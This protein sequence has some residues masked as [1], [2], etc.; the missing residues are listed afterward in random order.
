MLRYNFIDTDWVIHKKKLIDEVGGWDPAYYFDDYELWLR[1]SEN[2]DLCYLN[3]GLVENTAMRFP[4][5]EEPYE[6]VTYPASRARHAGGVKL[7]I[8]DFKA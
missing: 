3:K 6:R 5:L 4:F 8:T 7:P 2:H 1:I